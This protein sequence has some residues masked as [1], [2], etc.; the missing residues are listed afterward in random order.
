VA[1][2]FAHN[3]KTGKAMRR[4]RKSTDHAAQL[5]DPG[6]ELQ[7]NF[8]L[9]MIVEL[10]WFCSQMLSSALFLNVDHIGD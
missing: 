6:D 9:W 3:Q 2:D 5:A 8:L 1:V 10:L 7:G 4:Y